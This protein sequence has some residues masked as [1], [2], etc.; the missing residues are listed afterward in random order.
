[1][2]PQRFF[3]S[4]ATYLSRTSL[5]FNLYPQ[6]VSPH[7]GTITSL[8]IDNTSEGR[9]L[10]SGSQD[11]TVSVFDLNVLG[12]DYHLHTEEG[13]RS[14]NIGHRSRNNLKDR[15]QKQ[16]QKWR[17]K[18][19]FQAIA[20]SQRNFAVTGENHR[21]REQQLDPLYV[22]PGHS[23]SVTQV[24]WYPIDTGVFLSADK[25]GNILLWDTNSFTPISCL[26]K[27]IMDSRSMNAV[28]PCGISSID[29]PKLENASHML[30]AIGSIQGGREVGGTGRDTHSLLDPSGSRNGNESNIGLGAGHV[31]IDDRVVYLC[32][33]KSGS[34]THQL[35]GHGV[36]GI[37]SVQWS[38][39]HDY[40]LASG[41]RDGTVKLWDVRMSGS[42]ACL[43]TLDRENKTK[44]EIYFGSS[45]CN[46]IGDQE[47]EGHPN[48]HRTRV[49]K[50]RK[51][52]KVVGPGDYSAVEC[53]SYIQSHAGPV[54]SVAFA[55]DGNYIVSASTTDGLRLWDV[56]PGKDC[57]MMLP[58][59]Y[60]G[61]NHSAVSTSQSHPLDQK[62]KKVPLQIT[63]PGSFKSATVWVG[64]KNQQLLG[65]KLHG[66]EFGDGG[67]PD[68]VL[69]GH[70]DNVS[71]IASQD[72]YMRLYSGGNDGMILGF[73][74]KNELSP[75][76]KGNICQTLISL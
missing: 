54:A 4:Q 68:K 69:L 17:D 21:H 60:L 2:P 65:Y 7:H 53:S 20:K 42:G 73:G 41:S 63:Q 56:K 36:G 40:L 19:R 25:I 10:L 9:F 43:L 1:M 57:G 66:D 46:K 3:D 52:S 72:I 34:M 29:L 38:P 76:K 75:R 6:I 26:K 5:Q 28:S 59:R 30:L 12:S 35:V 14:S 31:V 55:P 37:S 71:A 18:N 58:T 44:N 61:V 23:H 49:R 39:I 11:C 70:L 51:K 50:R 8:D 24:Q 48:H 27:N 13:I 32:D 15:Q 16:K 64:G 62:Q 74:N 33:I 47:V 22:P 45:V 67:R